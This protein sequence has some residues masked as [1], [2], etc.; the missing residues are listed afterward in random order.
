[1]VLVWTITRSM[2]PTEIKNKLKYA[3]MRCLLD[4]GQGKHS[5]AIQNG[6]N[7]VGASPTMLSYFVLEYEYQIELDL[8]YLT[9]LLLY[10]G[11]NLLGDNINIIN[12]A[13]MHLQANKAGGIYVDLHR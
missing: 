6:M 2:K 4:I 1:M 9:Q 8:I 11:A 3:D 12:I 5:L 10:A 7:P 13:E